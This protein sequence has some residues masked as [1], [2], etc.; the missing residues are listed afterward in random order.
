M[1]TLVEDGELKTLRAM[2]E[3][4]KP[5]EP[6]GLRDKLA[7]LD[8]KEIKELPALATTRRRVGEHRDELRRVLAM[9]I[10]RRITGKV[11]IDLSQ[12]APCA[13]RSREVV[14]GTE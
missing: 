6:S 5:F 14:K 9:I 7:A 11:E 13:M 10:G 2:A 1:K 12:G 3:G 4:S 8:L